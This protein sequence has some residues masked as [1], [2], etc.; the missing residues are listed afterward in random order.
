MSQ[1]EYEILAGTG[2]SEPNLA[3]SA[4]NRRNRRS[5]AW[6]EAAAQQAL[7]RLGFEMIE[8]VETGF[9]VVRQGKRIVSAYPL[10]KVAG[11]FRAVAPGGRSVL[12]E[13]KSRGRDTLRWSDFEPH[14]REALDRHRELGGLSL[15]VW[16][17][18][19]GDLIVLRWPIPG[20][21]DRRSLPLELARTLHWAG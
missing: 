4:Q 1:E 21:G 17:P 12:V 9:G 16:L 8:R 11:D 7:E 14:Q 2:E 5:G 10:K 19:S 15:V 13:V 6:N 20:L 18:G 3:L